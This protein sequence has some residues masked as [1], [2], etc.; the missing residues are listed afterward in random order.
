MLCVHRL[1][2]SFSS[3]LEEVTI[4]AYG[5]TGRAEASKAVQLYSFLDPLKGAPPARSGMHR[6]M[7]VERALC[8]CAPCISC[9][10]T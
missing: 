3:G 7:G 6:S 4:I 2:S 1:L 8:S 9:A 5:E 10:R